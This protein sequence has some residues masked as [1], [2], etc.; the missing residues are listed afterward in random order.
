[1]A[2]HLP[3]IDETRSSIR[4]DGSRNHVH[5]ADVRGRFATARNVVFALLIGVY[6][7]IPFLRVGGRPAILLDVAHRRFFLLGATFNAQ[8]TWLAFF[9][10]TGL[11]F[12]LVCLTA[13]AGR[14]WCGW[15]CPQTVF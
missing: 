12:G 8:D 6:V 9:A 2:R 11:G 4:S 3:V 5:P 14:V 10:L 13:V 15:A 1:M 7:A